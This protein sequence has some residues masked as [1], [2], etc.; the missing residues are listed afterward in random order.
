M[1]ANSS[2]YCRAAAASIRCAGSPSRPAH[3]CRENAR[4]SSNRIAVRS[5]ISSRAAA[6]PNRS[7]KMPAP[8]SA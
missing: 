4:A 3:S 8:G 2:A 1:A 6:S 5:P 7:G